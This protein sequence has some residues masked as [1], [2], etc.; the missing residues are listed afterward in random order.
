[1][2]DISDGTNTTLAVGERPPSAY[3]D[4]GWW[5]PGWGQGKDGSADM[6]LGA[7]ERNSTNRACPPGPYQFLQG[8]VADPC[9]MFHFWS[10]HPGGANFLFADGSARFLSYEAD[11]ILPALATRAGGEIV[12]DSF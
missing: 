6:V 3:L 9:A 8:K 10:L 11:T 1:M 12:A 4:F 2:A 5:Y 7:Q